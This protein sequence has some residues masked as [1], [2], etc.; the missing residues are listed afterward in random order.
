MEALRT[1][2]ADRPKPGGY[3]S[4]GLVFVTKYGN[5]WA[6]RNKSEALTHE[7]G[8][9]LRKLNLHRPGLGFSTLRHVFRTVAD[10]TG[11][12]PAVRLVTGH[13]D[14]GID[15]VYRERIDD[16]RLVAVS[17]MVRKWLWPGGDAG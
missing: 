16:E 7:F 17:E 8:K 13:T 1:A 11:D 3:E 6:L 5:P 10:A 15:D 9:L 14:H 4:C 2:A 12:F